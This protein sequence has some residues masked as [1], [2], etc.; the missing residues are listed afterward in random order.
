MSTPC[1]SAASK[2]ATV[3]PG[4]TWSAPLWPTLIRPGTP[5]TSRSCGCRRPG[6]GPGCRAAAA[7]G[8]AVALVHPQLARVPAALGRSQH[9]RPHRADAAS[10]SS[11]L[12]S[13]S[14][15]P[16]VE[17]G[18]E[19]GLGLPDVPDPA[20]V[21]L[22]EQGVADAARGVVL[23]QA[24]QERAARRTRRPGCPGR[25][26]RSAGRSGCATRSSA[27]APARRT[28][29][30]RARRCGLRAR[31]GARA[32]PALTA[33]VD[34][35][36]PLMR[37]CECSVSSPSKRMNRCLPWESTAR[38]ARPAA[39][40]ASGPARSA[41]GASRSTRSPRRRARRGRAWPR[42]GSCRPRA[43]PGGKGPGVVREVPSA[44]PRSTR[45]VMPLWLCE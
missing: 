3:F 41:P 31:R 12:T 11:S 9:Q 30:P 36:P 27:R 23:A 21:A 43:C 14:G 39:A 28:G 7:A 32:P 13:P 40:P 8:P 34:A 44:S 45:S 1:S 10:A 26:A 37:R 2:L 25:A 16:R 17:P 5:G 18:E 22:V 29:R 24:A 6:R 42:G 4:A 38:T 20:Q 33:P 35:P 15:L 19:A